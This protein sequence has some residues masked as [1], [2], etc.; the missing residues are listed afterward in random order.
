MVSALPCSTRVGMARSV[1]LSFNSSIASNSD[2]P[3]RLVAF[4]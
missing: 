2:A 4:G 3:R 1:R